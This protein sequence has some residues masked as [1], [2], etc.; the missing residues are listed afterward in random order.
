MKPNKNN[1]MSVAIGL[2]AGL[3]IF[4]FLTKQG[5]EILICVLKYLKQ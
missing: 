3:L 5:N 1:K 2:L 4:L